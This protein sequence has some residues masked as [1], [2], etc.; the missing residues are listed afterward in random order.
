MIR[1]TTPLDLAEAS[2]SRDRRDRIED[3]AER[4]R[5]LDRT[6][7]AFV[8]RDVL[9]MRIGIEQQRPEGE[10]ARHLGRA[11]KRHVEGGRHLRRRAREIDLDAVAADS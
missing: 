8:L 7:R 2:L 11:L 9:L 1:S 3:A 10:E 4:R 5:H 6:E